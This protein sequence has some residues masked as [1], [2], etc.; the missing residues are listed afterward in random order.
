MQ[1]LFTSFLIL[2]A[3][4]IKPGISQISVGEAAVPFAL[5]DTSGQ[6]I[7]LEDFAGQVVMLNFFATWCG[8]CQVEAPL[9]EDSIWTVYKDNDFVLIGLDFREDKH[10][11]SQF[12]KQF[13]LTYPVVLDSLGQVFDAYR[14]RLFPTSVIIDQN[15]YVAYVKEGFNIQEFQ[16]VIDSL[17]QLTSVKNDP[18]SGLPPDQLTLLQNFPNP[19]N[20]TTHIRFE[21]KTTDLVTLQIFS[22]EGRKI[23]QTVQRFKAGRNQIKINL[24]EQASGIYLYR[25]RSQNSTVNGRFILQK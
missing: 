17:L 11:A 18:V 19:F 14:L 9:L 4:L 10:L 12:I 8:P 5:P 6:I 15:G 23:R 16:S 25:L 3:L 20:G 22:S 24:N 21:L 7:K 13:G 1:K 2:G